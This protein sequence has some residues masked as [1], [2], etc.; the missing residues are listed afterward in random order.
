MPKDVTQ[1]ILHLFHSAAKHSY[2]LCYSV[3]KQWN[4]S[5]QISMYLM[6]KLVINGGHTLLL[7]TADVA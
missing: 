2:A 7:H 4:T 3:E 6:Q 5:E 1:H